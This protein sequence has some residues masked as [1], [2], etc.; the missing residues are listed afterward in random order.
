GS[1][2]LQ[3]A[4]QTSSQLNP[5]PSQRRKTIRQQEKIMPIYDPVH[6]EYNI[7]TGY[8][9]VNLDDGSQF[10]AYMAHPQLA[11]TYPAISLLHDWWGITSMIR[12]LANVLAQSGHYVIIPDLFDGKVAKTPREA[13]QLVEALGHINGMARV[14]AAIDVVEKHNHTNGTSAVVGL[15]MGGS[16]AYDV[17]LDCEDVEAAVSIGGF[18]QR[19]ME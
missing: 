14:C 18:P 13:M 5:N 9:Q 7:E 12:W 10:P 3:V 11:G 8:V 6:I 4:A 2:H 1:Q 19:N 16:F 17:A 15:G